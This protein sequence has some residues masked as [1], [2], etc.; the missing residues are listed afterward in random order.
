MHTYESRRALSFTPCSIRGA[1][2]IHMDKSLNYEMFFFVVRLEMSL[3]SQ[4]LIVPV[5]VRTRL[6]RA[7]LRWLCCASIVVCHALPSS[8]SLFLVLSSSFLKFAASFLFSSM[9]RCH[10]RCCKS[11]QGGINERMKAKGDSVYSR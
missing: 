6:L 5:V 8:L 4:H 9:I 7:H 11:L 2:N 10:D 1:Q 3:L